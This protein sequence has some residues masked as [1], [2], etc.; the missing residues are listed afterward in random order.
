MLGPKSFTCPDTEPC[1]G[2]YQNLLENLALLQTKRRRAG[3]VTNSG[4]GTLQRRQ[5]QIRHFFGLAHELSETGYRVHA[6]LRLCVVA[7]VLQRGL[8]LRVYLSQLKLW[9]ITFSYTCACRTESPT[10]KHDIQS[11]GLF[12]AQ[13]GAGVDS[14]AKSSVSPIRPFGKNECVPITWAHVTSMRPSWWS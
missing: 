11:N 3:C 8:T 10:Q 7:S 13:P 12:L 2:A 1:N 4:L 6:E 9:G 14:H 5:F